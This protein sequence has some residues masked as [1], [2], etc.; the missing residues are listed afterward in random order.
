[1]GH[2]YRNDSHFDRLDE[3]ETGAAIRLTDQYGEV[4]EYEVYDIQ[5]IAPDETHAL[6]DYEGEHGLALITYTT[7]GKNRLLV[8][9]RLTSALG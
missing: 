2:N 8:K 4:Y 6:E 5:T 9:C 3:L 1:M 7:G